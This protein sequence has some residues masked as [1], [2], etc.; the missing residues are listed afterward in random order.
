MPSTFL[1]CYFMTTKLSFFETQRGAAELAID[2]R[3]VNTL[4]N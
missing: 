3:S 4:I 1:P 2:R